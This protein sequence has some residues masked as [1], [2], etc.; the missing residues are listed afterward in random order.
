M[1]KMQCS[2]TC[3][4]KPGNKCKHLTNQINS[5]NPTI[6]ST[7]LCCYRNNSFQTTSL[8]ATKG[9]YPHFM[10]HSPDAKNLEDPSSVQ[11]PRH[12]QCSGCR[13]A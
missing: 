13:V 3:K 2:F 4:S 5:H 11:W 6:N 7:L 9:S 1:M 10:F 8:I 12:H